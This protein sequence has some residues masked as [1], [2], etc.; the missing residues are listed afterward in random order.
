MRILVA[1]ACFLTLLAGCGG[2]RVERDHGRRRPQRQRPERGRARNDGQVE[3]GLL[4][5][6]EG[7]AVVESKLL[8]VIHPLHL[9]HQMRLQNGAAA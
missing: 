7:V 8:F 9:A 1:S 5:R 6:L 2:R 3:A 4:L